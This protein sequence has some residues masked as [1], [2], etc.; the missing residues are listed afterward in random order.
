[1]NTRNYVLTVLDYSDG[2]TYIFNDVPAE[3]AEAD[4]E[5][6][7]EPWLESVDNPVG[8]FN[9]DEISYMVTPDGEYDVEEL[10][11]DELDLDDQAE[12]AED[13][14]D[15]DDADTDDTM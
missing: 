5:E 11:F 6:Y 14:D 15:V 12:D 9:L 2:K 7:L 8:G 13:V 10:E 4:A 1:M 3:I